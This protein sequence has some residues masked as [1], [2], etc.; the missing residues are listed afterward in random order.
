MPHHFQPPGLDTIYSD[1]GEEFVG[2]DDVMGTISNED[3]IGE[4]TA[5]VEILAVGVYFTLLHTFRLDSRWTPD[6]LRISTW[7]PYGLHLQY[8]QSYIFH[9]HPPGVHLE[10]A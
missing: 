6:G 8:N 4:A 10:S 5:A 7:T 9:D 2:L 1:E 3:N